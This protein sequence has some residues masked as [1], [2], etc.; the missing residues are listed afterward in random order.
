M[1]DI[2]KTGASKTCTYNFHNVKARRFLTLE[3]E[4]PE[5]T[6][7]PTMLVLEKIREIGDATNGAIVRLILNLP[8]NLTTGLR[9]AEIFKA[10]K[11][12]Y[13]VSMVKEIHRLTR[14]RMPGSITSSM[15][16]LD[17]LKKYLENINLPAGRNKKLLE[18][19]ERLINDEALQ[20]RGTYAK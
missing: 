13:N 14:T 4:V 17:A 20:D 8:A 15:S 9:E 7:D 5:N 12:A 1:V 6:P 18:Y 10:L 11:D 2:N 3:V 16:P 19:G